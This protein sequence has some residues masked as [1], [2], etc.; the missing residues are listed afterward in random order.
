MDHPAI[1]WLSFWLFNVAV[2]GAAAALTVY[3]ARTRQ[4]TGTYLCDDCRFNDAK[5]CLKKER[6]FA[7]ACTSYRDVAAPGFRVPAAPTEEP[8]AN[9][10][11]STG[12][13][14][15]ASG[16]VEVTASETTIE[17]SS[18]DITDEI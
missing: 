7:V 12:T 6:P 11:E 3:C 1:S 8:A 9:V 4:G 16:I 13:A 17:P 2:A 10:V 15:S 5:S 18:L 14:Y